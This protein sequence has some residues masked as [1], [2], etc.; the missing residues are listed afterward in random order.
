MGMCGT[1]RRQLGRWP[2]TQDLPKASDVYLLCLTWARRHDVRHHS[3]RPLGRL[4]HARISGRWPRLLMTPSGCRLEIFLVFGLILAGPD[5]DRSQAY[6]LGA[7][8][9][10][11]PVVAHHGHLVRRQVQVR[12]R[13]AEK[14]P[15]A[16]LPT[17]PG[18]CVRWQ[19]PGRLRTVPCPA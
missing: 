9:V 14:I 17:T 11:F 2:S 10:G 13:Q 16:G 4:S 18:R 3:E 15:L 6:P 1:G 8:N 19:T 7:C 5:Q 12:E